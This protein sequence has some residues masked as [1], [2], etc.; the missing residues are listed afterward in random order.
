MD[1]KAVYI[2]TYRKDHSFARICIASIRYWYPQIPIF[3]IK[4][5]GAGD[6]DTHATEEAWN[7]QVLDTGKKTFGWG[8]GK[9]EPLFRDGAGSFLFMD[10]DTVM[11]GPVLDLVKDIDAD[12]IVDEEVQSA[13]ELAK[14]YYDPEGLRKLYPDFRYPGYSFNTGQWFG[15]SGFLER[16]DLD[17]FVTWTTGPRLRHPEVFKQADQGLYNFLLQRKQAEGKLR[18]AR[19]PLMIWPD[20][21]AADHVDLEAIRSKE[22]KEA[23]VIHWAGMKQKK[24]N[25]LPRQDI[26]DFFETVYYRGAGPYR[27]MMD[28]SIGLRDMMWDGA[29]R[30]L[31]RISRMVH[32]DGTDR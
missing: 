23:R 15:T 13:D 1:V 9:F 14:L 12:F 18:V 21:G 20:G 24:G 25:E 2:N 16:K 7:V 4:D 11:T 17:E 27:K 8:F 3:L 22:V 6:F 29:G 32:A 31:R 19:I 26:L 28:R 30:M 10:A 5:M